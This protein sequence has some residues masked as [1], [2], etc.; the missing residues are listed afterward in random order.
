MNTAAQCNALNCTVVEVLSATNQTYAAC[1][2]APRDQSGTLLGVVA[3]IGSLALLMV[4][5][6]LPIVPSLVRR[7][8][9]G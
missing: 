6:R 7:N 2:V 8:L 5:L 1:G 4:I 9:V 3:S